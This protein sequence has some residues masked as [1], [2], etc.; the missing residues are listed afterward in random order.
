MLVHPYLGA[1]EHLFDSWGL[2]TTSPALTYWFH[3]FCWPPIYMA[4]THLSISG[5][6]RALSWEEMLSVLPSLRQ[7]FLQTSPP[8]S[9]FHGLPVPWPWP[10]TTSASIWFYLPIICGLW[11]AP[12]LVASLTGPCHILINLLFNQSTFV[13]FISQNHWKSTQ[14]H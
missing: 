2:G 1:S 5:S 14:F 7:T 6:K 10:P 8:G 12:G 4:H 9:P 13:L 3:K 11:S